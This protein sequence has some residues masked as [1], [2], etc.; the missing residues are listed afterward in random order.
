MPISFVSNIKEFAKWSTL[1]SILT[2][3]TL[4]CLTINFAEIVLSKNEKSLNLHLNKNMFHI[5]KIPYFIGIATGAFSAAAIYF[6]V[7][8]SLKEPKAFLSIF[9]KVTHVITFFYGF[10]GF[11]GY[12]AYGPNARDLILLNLPRTNFIYA[13][14]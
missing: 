3:I 5:E 10:I 4:I 8:S 13:L 6:N 14:S 12:L 2:I 9:F 7:R 11:T 1:A